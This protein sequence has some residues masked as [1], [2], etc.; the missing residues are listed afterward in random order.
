MGSAESKLKFRNHAFR[1]TEPTKQF[2]FNDDYWRTFWVQPESANDVFNTLTATDIRSIRDTNIKGFC[3]LLQCI[4]NRLI[5]LTRINT[6]TADYPTHELLN[7]IRLLTKLLPF[8]Y[9]RSD[10]QSV[11]R[12]VFWSLDTSLDSH[13]PLS[14]GSNSAIVGVDSLASSGSNEASITDS[15]HANADFPT[16]KEKLNDAASMKANFD[17]GE[18]ISKPNL[19]LGARLVFICVDLL[20]TSGFTVAA[21]ELKPA[22][23]KAQKSSNVEF[24]I[25]E[26]GV[27]LSGTP[28][29]PDLYLDSNRLEVLRLLISLCSQCLYKQVSNVI[30][31]GSRYMTVLVTSTPKLQ[32]LTLISSLVNTTCRST[33]ENT[34]NNSNENGLEGFS[35]NSLKELRLL[36]VTNAIQLFTLMIVYPLPKLDLEFL[37]TT[38]ILSDSPTNLVRFYC[39]RLYKDNEIRLLEQGI[40]LPLFRPMEA[41]GSGVNSSTT[42]AG[43][44]MLMKGKSFGNTDPSIWST[45][46][47]ILFWEFYQCNRKFRNYVATMLG[48][49]V[50]IVLM[51][52]ISTYKAAEKYRN[53]VRTCS[54]LMTFLTC[55]QT[56]SSVL[57]T[58]MDKNYYS[59]FPVSYRISTPLTTYRDFLVVHTCN[60][61]ISDCPAILAPTMTEIL[62]NLVPISPP[63]T[64]KTD[65]PTFNRRLSSK[66]LM[67]PS[68]SSS[69]IN[70]LSYGA[71]SSLT[72]LVYKYSAP[73]LL[74][75]NNTN[76]DLLAL[77]LRSICQYICRNPQNSSIFLYILA[78]H[79]DAYEGVLRSIKKVS[80]NLEDELN[81][82]E[83][84]EFPSHKGSMESDTASL[85]SPLQRP[86]PQ[87]QM[88]QVSQ[89]SVISNNSSITLKSLYSADDNID[90]VLLNSITEGEVFEET[91][92]RPRL[93]VGMS[94]K[95]KSKLPLYASLE[96][97]WTGLHACKLLLECIKFVQSN[98][99]IFLGMDVA[100]AINKISG[101][102]VNEFLQDQAIPN[103][104]NPSKSKFEPLKF[105]WSNLSLGWYESV[106]WNSVYN[107][108]EIIGNKTLFVEISSSISAL[109]KVGTDW[110]LGSWGSSSTSIASSNSSKKPDSE[111][112]DRAT[113]ALIN[114]SVWN[115]TT[116]KLFTTKDKQTSNILPSK[117]TV[118][119]VTDSFIKRFGSVGFNKRNSSAASL[120][121]II[122][123]PSRNQSLTSESNPNSPL[124]IQQPTNIFQN[125][126]PFSSVGSNPG[127]PG[128]NN[129][130]I[131]PPMA[132]DFEGSNPTSLGRGLSQSDFSHIQLRLTPR[133]SLSLNSP[134]KVS[135]SGRSTP[136]TSSAQN[137]PILGPQP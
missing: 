58:Q 101:L 106:L 72:Q 40:L 102:N 71:A 11:E 52:Y 15:I 10:L 91:I 103:E 85:F 116:V 108:N 70:D 5:Q 104:Y 60:V 62:Y 74:S 4:S 123:S 34:S 135:L 78:R 94:M 19:P 133:N 129:S 97:T 27:G 79:H 37:K 98:I 31:I 107:N 90:P 8:L 13:S 56:I 120:H 24:S 42:G 46:L 81:V 68:T 73:Q 65:P 51:Y 6:N 25:W 23:Q 55:D 100:A 1:L 38:N 30:P 35:N 18:L 29:Q 99:T 124:L 44:S 9:E 36:M 84:N 47:V 132:T 86:I 50:I 111:L 131:P 128:F 92:I 64:A 54:Y 32:L 130:P 28:Q 2:S 12:S 75:E 119:A 7:C 96:E 66:D 121:S 83:E 53:L 136:R 16:D 77:I 122:T 127:S 57:A 87:R 88:S 26:P 69:S 117:G 137:T 118:D 134:A 33:K 80:Q 45:E 126:N 125:Q 105:T 112:L 48:T 20:L 43:L 93:P 89:N 61:L 14:Q 3:L 115:G 63:S 22:S 41:A 21:S 110:G 82:Q 39:G 59:T 95:A 113:K 67:N 109:K 49:K 17:D 114:V 76:L